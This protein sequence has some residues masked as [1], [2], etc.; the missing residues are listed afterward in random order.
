M[1]LL[2]MRTKKRMLT[3]NSPRGHSYAQCPPELA[4]ETHTFSYYALR[5]II[6][7]PRP[8]TEEPPTQMTP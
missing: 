1:Y 4:H 3:C 8:H 6:P 2:R 5:R 7:I